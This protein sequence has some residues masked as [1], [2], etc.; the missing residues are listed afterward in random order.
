MAGAGGVS[1]SEH[2]SISFV[3]GMGCFEPLT[4]ALRYLHTVY[5]FRTLDVKLAAAE[6]MVGAI[7]IEETA[8]I[9]LPYA[10]KGVRLLPP[11]YGY[12]V[13]VCAQVGHAHS[14]KHS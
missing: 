14:S 1:L 4:K 6:T 12:Q 13:L 11:C 3:V 7:A 2:M 8:S 9:Y 5:S 10:V